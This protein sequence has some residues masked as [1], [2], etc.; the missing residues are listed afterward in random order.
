[1]LKSLR[2]A[3]L[4][5][6]SGTNAFA[7]KSTYQQA[8]HK[9]PLLITDNAESAIVKEGILLPYSDKISHEASILRLLL[10]HKV[11]WI[12]LAGYMRILSASFIETFR[13]WHKQ[14]NQILNIHPSLLPKYK[15]KNAYKQA[16]DSSDSHT[17]ISIHY[18]TKE[19]DAGDIIVQV[20][21]SIDRDLDFEDFVARSKKIENDLYCQ[22]LQRIVSGEIET[23]AFYKE[24]G[25]V[26]KV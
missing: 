9:E 12:F 16:W 6:G 23:Q 18:V 1:M 10:E 4:A 20:P 11:D 2:V 21:F 5:S 19:V 7:L 25:L 8:F 17:G 15:G 13:S 3:I 26:F 24:D 14:K 22:V